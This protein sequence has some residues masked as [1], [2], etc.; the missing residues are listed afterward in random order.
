MQTEIDYA[1]RLKASAQFLRRLDDQAETWTFQTFDDDSGRKDKS[2]VRT[3]HGTLEQHAAALVHLNDQGAGVFVTVNETDGTAR[4]AENITRVRAIWVDLDGAPL[5]PCRDWEEPHVIVQTSPG[6]WHAYW[7]IEGLE[8]AHMPLDTFKSEFRSRQ[9]T[10]IRAFNSDKSVNDLPRVMRLPGFYHR[11]GEPFLTHEV[12]TISFP[13]PLRLEEIDMRLSELMPKSV[14]VVV[15]KTLRETLQEQIAT[16]PQMDRPTQAEVADALSYIDPDTGG[17]K[18]WCDTLMAIHDEFNAGGLALAE[19]WSSRGAK[20]RQGEVAQKFASF[21]NGGGVT[22]SYV[23]ARAKSAGCDV[24]G[25]AKKHR[26]K[27]TSAK[28]NPLRTPAPDGIELTEDGV[29]RHFTRMHKD[30]LRF[31]HDAGSWYEWA[32]DYWRQDGT[33]RAF[34]YCREAARR[35]SIDSTDKE[36]MTAR[37]ASFAAGVERLAKAD[38]DHAVRQSVW[39]CDPWVVGTPGGVVDLKNGRS[40]P[41]APSDMITKRLSVAPAQ[42]PQCPRWLKFLDEST[43]GDFDLIRFLQQWC[44]YS[45]TGIT[46]EHALVFMYGGGGNGKSVFLN[47]LSGILGDY[48]TQASMDTFTASKHDRHP[49]DLAALRGSRVVTA[50]ETEEGRAWAEARIKALTGGDKI[51]ARFMRQDFFEFTPQFK[52]IIAGNHRPTLRNI[53]PAMQRRLNIVPFTRKPATPD[54]DLENKLKAEFPGILRWMIDGALDWQQNGLIRPDS[55]SAATAAYFEENDLFGTFLQE[56]CETDTDNDRW[57]ES[58]AGLFKRWQEY[59]IAAGDDPASARWMGE[60]MARRGFP[61]LKKACNGTREM[62]FV[63]VRLKEVGFVARD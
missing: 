26:P 37:K 25:L 44:G 10:L 23:F 4:K 62:A 15:D 35:A 61:K 58:A 60:N 52:L 41:A 56:R 54:H 1:E 59:A 7:L 49:T 42:T 27:S 55:V 47:T 50:S 57:F 45:L 11:K 28:R 12:E 16:A 31:D 48:A 43:G 17:Y 6:K 21:K 18:D 24:G 13:H 39:D 8:A 63:G 34:N 32:G 20:Y 51:S 29:A 46:R 36:M 38:P 53:D 2:L 22:I 30:R 9:E 40:R 33:S 3:L 19:D 5:E 14:P